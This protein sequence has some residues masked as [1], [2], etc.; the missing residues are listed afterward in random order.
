MSAV[1][2]GPYVGD[3]EM[4]DS[5]WELVENMK[6]DNGSSMVVVTE[7][8]YRTEVMDMG[9]PVYSRREL[10]LIHKLTKSADAFRNIQKLKRVFPECKVV[11]VSEH[12]PKNCPHRTE[13]WKLYLDMDWPKPKKRNWWGK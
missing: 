1:L 6:V 12:E 9:H 8:M 3:T 2:F 7:E 11:E 10:G 5:R 13:R 4:S